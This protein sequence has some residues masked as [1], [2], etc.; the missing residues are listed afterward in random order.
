M[1]EEGQSKEGEIQTDSYKYPFDL[2]WG[3]DPN[4]KHIFQGLKSI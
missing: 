1:A 3:K 4:P 2:N